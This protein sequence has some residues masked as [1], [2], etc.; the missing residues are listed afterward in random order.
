VQAPAA[1]TTLTNLENFSEK[2]EKKLFCQK[3]GRSITK[4]H[5]IIT[6]A[7]ED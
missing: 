7:G 3:T 2:V 6:N 1:L 5:S 4:L